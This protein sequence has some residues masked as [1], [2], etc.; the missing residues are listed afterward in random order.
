MEDTKIKSFLLPCLIPKVPISALHMNKINKTIFNNPYGIELC[1]NNSRHIL[2]NRCL[3]KNNKLNNESRSST[4]TNKN[5][6]TINQNH[7]LLLFNLF[8]KDN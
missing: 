5:S 8:G 3:N 1:N 6:D 7:K 2:Y 4:P